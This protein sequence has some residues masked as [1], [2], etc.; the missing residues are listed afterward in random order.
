[1][2]WKNNDK[3]RQRLKLRG[4]GDN[5]QRLVLIA[6]LVTIVVTVFGA[7]SYTLYRQLAGA[8]FFLVTEINIAGSKKISKE[9]VVVLSGLDN[10]TNLLAVDLGQVRDSLKKNGW[11]DEVEIEKKWPNRLEI[12]LTD[13]VPVALINTGGDLYYVDRNGK[14]IN[15]VTPLEDMDYPVISVADLVLEGEIAE[16]PAIKEALAFL[17]CAEQGNSNLPK[18][19][20][21]ELHLTAGAELVLFLAENPFPIYLG[22]GEM[23]KKYSRLGNVLSQ[24]YKTKEFSKTTYIRMDYWNDRVLVGFVEEGKAPESKK[25]G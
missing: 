2:A 17:R 23:K 21:S 15:E 22:H 8:D 10:N 25:N 5:R 16:N 13:K 19:N 24:L 18:Q 20:I 14:I 3:Q 12:T 11:I 1:M 7:G 4:S 9:Q 6:L